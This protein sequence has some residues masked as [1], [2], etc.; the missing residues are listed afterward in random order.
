VEIEQDFGQRRIEILN[1][2]ARYTS[3]HCS[4]NLLTRSTQAGEHSPE[5]T[6]INAGKITYIRKKHL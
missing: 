1:I 6:P 5:G 4:Q 3:R 2:H